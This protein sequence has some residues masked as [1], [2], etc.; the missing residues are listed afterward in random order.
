MQYKK[1]SLDVMNYIKAFA[2]VALGIFVVYIILQG[3]FMLIPIVLVCW[4]A[5]KLIKKLNIKTE[6]FKSKRENQ[7]FKDKEVYYTN[8]NDEFDT[9][10]VDVE[11]KEV[12]K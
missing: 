9:N 4:V 12:D 3:I 6:N 1:G 7:H 8:T 5:Y 11:Y 10:V 2:K